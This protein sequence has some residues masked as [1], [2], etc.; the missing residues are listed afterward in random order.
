[1]CRSFGD[2]FKK[3]AIDMAWELLT[4]VYHLPPD[5]L[6]ATY[7][8]GD[9]SLGLP[10]DNE[11][12]DLWLRH[13]PAHK[14]LP[15]G[16]KD[17]FWEMG[18][19]GPCGP[20]TEIHY[21]RLGGRDASS[22]VNADDPTCIE[23]WNNVFM[24]F[25]REP[26][27][28]LRPLPAKHV[29]TGMGFERLVSILQNKPSNY[30]TDVFAPLFAAIQAA[31]GA[32]PYSGKLGAEDVDNVDTAYRVVAD[33]IRTLSFAIADGAQPGPEGRNYVLRRILRRAVRYG[34]DCLR[35][36]EGFFSGLVPT[37]QAAMGGQFP[38]LITRGATIQAIIAE[39]EA[40]FGRTLVK[41]LAE[42]NKMAAA[43]TA[44]GSTTIAGAD[45]FLLWDTFG[46]PVDLTQ[47]MAE[48]RRMSVDAAGFNAAM[49]EAKARSRQAG[50]KAGERTIAF[51][52]EATAQLA[53]NGVSPTDDSHK[54]TWH[55]DVRA[56][57]R[58]LLTPDAGF[59]DSVDENTAGPVG[60]VLDATPFY[61][62]SGGQVAD[63]GCITLQASG[64]VA[65]TVT[66][67]LVAAGY[68]LHIGAPARRLA[69]GDAVTGCVD[70]GRRG[71]VAPNHTLT[72]VMNHAL[73]DVLGT[74]VEQ[75]GSLVDADKLRFDFSHPKPVEDA[76][77]SAIEAAVRAAV[78]D[79]RPVHAAEVPLAKA[80][81]ISGL[82]AVFGETY[83][84]P[85]R[86]VSVG[87]SVDALLADPGNAKKWAPVAVEF[88]GGTH[89]SNT[90]QAEAFALL[91]EEGIAKGVRRIV[92][93]TR[94][95]AQEAI[96]RGEA[97]AAELRAIGACPAEED[98]ALEARLAP[99]KAQLAAAVIPAP[100]KADLLAQLSELTKRAIAAAKALAGAN[101]DKAVAACMEAASAGAKVVAL[102]C[103]VGTD[104]DA[105]RAGTTAAQQQ[106]GCAMAVVS[107]DVDKDKVMVYV[108]VP[109]ELEAKGLD[110]KAWLTAAL[111]PVGGKGGGGKGLAQGQFAG[112]AKTD[113]ALAAARQFAASH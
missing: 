72:H 99:F 107:A 61:A 100:A 15:F 112:V 34:R 113:E 80:K 36:P 3:D 41:G 84:D 92:A 103:D 2:Y 33:H 7:F 11:A 44:A 81:A 101:K 45:A 95:A 42:F 76:Q 1:V 54:Y 23:I 85:V 73:R 57:V 14:I 32:R 40:S 47:L 51:E 56:T 109:P 97:L 6:Y 29:D 21:D 43:A 38:E 82:R 20:C 111:A 104:A 58:A 10:P 74:H 37:L 49:E 19:T 27:R 16:C 48:E 59:V 25:N 30:D 94:S 53:K 75:R 69:V 67:A 88:C 9:S 63:T 70:Y 93:V 106:H 39:E 98:F 28:S 50:K 90:S 96:A 26:D 71:L 68:V 65:V 5:R 18:D 35:A 91:S 79:A 62:E 13:L 17:N 12:R 64:H 87:A 89:V 8:G 83:P 4:Q 105:L 55:V 102:R 78:V 22:L 86:V 66:N 77:L 24:Q 31:T 52:A 60:V 46:F 108:S 110:C